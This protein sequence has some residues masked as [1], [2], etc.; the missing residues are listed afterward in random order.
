MLVNLY[1]VASTLAH[2]F[3]GVATAVIVV[4]FAVAR[5]RQRLIG[6]RA[7]RLL[8]VTLGVALYLLSSPLVARWAT[9]SL[10]ALVPRVPTEE[11]ATARAIV[12]LAGGFRR[13]P[14]GRGELA[15]DSVSRCLHAAA[16]YRALGSRTV[17]V[18]GGFLASGPPN[19][20]AARGMR[21][22]LVQLGVRSEHIIEEGRSSTTYENAAETRRLLAEKGLDRIALVTSSTHLPRSI[23]VFEGQGFHVIP[24]GSGYSNRDAPWRV[25]DLLPQASAADAVNRAAHEWVGLAWY[26]LHGRV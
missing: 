26:R 13:G 6:L 22:F 25:V 24:A 18:S 20:P 17:V 15:L 16:V 8:S 2:P 4:L 11:L 3:S 5:Q 21:D 14:D 1:E 23:A 10:E 7:V 9:Q 12:V 19:V